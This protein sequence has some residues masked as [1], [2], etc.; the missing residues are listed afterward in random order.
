MI[1]TD[2]SCHYDTYRL[3]ER[4]G[5]KQLLCIMSYVLISSTVSD[6]E[7]NKR[8]LDKYIQ[9][10][11]NEWEPRIDHATLAKILSTMGDSGNDNAE[12]GIPA[13]GYSGISLDDLHAQAQYILWRLKQISAECLHVLQIGSAKDLRRPIGGLLSFVIACASVSVHVDCLPLSVH[14]VQN[15]RSVS[16]MQHQLQMSP[17]FAAGLDIDELDSALNSLD[18]LFTEEEL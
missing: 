1:S 6:P 12:I 11:E 17:L 13:N 3:S 9:R 15:E 16:I 7:E 14:L 5:F 10:D 8:L 4:L 2:G 18:L